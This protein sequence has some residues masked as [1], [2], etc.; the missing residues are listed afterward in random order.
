MSAMGESGEGDV[1]VKT[2]DAAEE[3][4]HARRI[5]RILGYVR[6]KMDVALAANNELS[7]TRTQMVQMGAFLLVAFVIGTGGVESL[8]EWKEDSLAVAAVS[9]LVVSLFVLRATRTSAIY[10]DIV[11]D[12]FHA[13]ETIYSLIVWETADDL[14]ALTAEIAAVERGTRSRIDAENKRHRLLTG[15][16]L[17]TM[18]HYE[19]HSPFQDDIGQSEHV[20]P[21]SNLDGHRHG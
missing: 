21:V 15:T 1:G 7:S 2:L 4:L 16:I 3:I 8:L 9:A 14:E 10:T 11:M 13:L 5:D 18:I 12:E 19:R 20:L 17:H 6:M